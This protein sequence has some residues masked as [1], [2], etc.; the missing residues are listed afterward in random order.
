MNRDYND[1]QYKKWRSAVFRR[2]R[3]RC[4][5]CKSKEKLH[6]HHIRTWSK[7]PELRYVVGNGITLCKRC[8]SEMWGKEELWQST[9]HALLNKKEHT[10]LMMRLRQL[11]REEEELDEG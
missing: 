3:Y 2:D 6:A 1:P 8:H 7:A 11:E 10:N 4:L 5:K 9:C